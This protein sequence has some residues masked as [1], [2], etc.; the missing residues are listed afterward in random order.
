M[1]GGEG[2]GVEIDEWKLGEN[3]ISPGSLCE[4]PVGFR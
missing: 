2:K 4:R 3:K 1:I